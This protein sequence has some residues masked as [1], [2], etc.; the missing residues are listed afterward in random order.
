MKRNYLIALLLV[1]LLGCNS[2]Q[3]ET[4]MTRA[5]PDS[6]F[7]EP[8]LS[9][10]EFTKQQTKALEEMIVSVK[11]AYNYKG[12]SYHEPNEA[13]KL[14]AVDVEFSNYSKDFDPDEVEII[15]GDTNEVY[16]IANTIAPLNEKGEV[17]L[18]EHIMPEAPGPV[19]LLLVYA[20]PK[21]SNSL[22]LRYGG[23]VIPDKSVKL[24]EGGLVLKDPEK[25]G[26]Q[27]D[28]PDGQ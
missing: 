3:D 28:P 9:L 2:S 4:D 8:M 20:F 25:Q 21:G 1:G 26:G 6:G 15:N 7:T 12:F 27:A 11:A 17:I 14:I 16:G 18:E 23:R 19:R 13:E 24:K 22:K 10:E 5:D